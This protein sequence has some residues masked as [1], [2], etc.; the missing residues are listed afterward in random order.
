MLGIFH[1]VVVMSMSVAAKSEGLLS[2]PG[3]EPR[4]VAE[5]MSSAS[6]DAGTLS[7]R[8]LF[9]H[10]PL[11]WPLDE[12]RPRS[13]KAYSQM[14][15]EGRDPQVAKGSLG[16]LSKAIVDKVVAATALVLAMPLMAIVAVL[17]RAG[18]G[19]P[20]IF[21]HPRIGA[22]GRSFRCYKFRTMVL[23][24]DDV[25]AAHLAACPD[26]ASEWAATRKL[27]NDPRVT[28]IGRLLRRSS[29][30]ELPQLVNVLRGEMSCVG[31][32]PVVEEELA[33]Y[34]DNAADYLAARPGM[35][36]LWQISGRSR[37]GY[38]DRVKL[39]ALYVRQWTLGL[40]MVILIK[41][42]P[43]VLRTQDAS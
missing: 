5:P 33:R 24:G 21:G 2:G 41:T 37:L 15:N 7:W 13:Q 39:D 28:S 36:G 31:P 22:N 3:S 19:G 23:N 1:A 43:A 16:G 4:P 17:I 18:D 10:G 32:R 26:S 38:A 29:L 34:G 30:D 40:D 8:L 42:I 12:P 11:R 9:A 20:A 35:T 6:A 27:K 25:L 14:S